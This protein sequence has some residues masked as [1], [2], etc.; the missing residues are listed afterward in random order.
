MKPLLLIFG[1]LMCLQFFAEPAFAFQDSPAGDITEQV[2]GDQVDEAENGEQSEVRELTGLIS[3]GKIVAAI[4]ILIVTW[5]AIYLINNILDNLSE[6]ATRYRL[7]IKR[8]T[9][10]VRVFIWTMAIYVIIVG[11]I[12]PPFEALVTIAASLGIAVGFASQDVLKNIFGG[13]LI[14]FD[15]PFQVGDKIRVGSDYG[16][17]L[18]IGLRST[19]IV[20]P[21][22]SVV[23]LPNGE[24]M[25]KAVSNTNTG[26]L[27]CQV[28]SEIFMPA[29]TDSDLLKSIAYRSVYSS[30]YVYLNK[31]VEV[32]VINEIY[33]QNFVIKLR[34]KAYVLD[35]RYEF[36]FL[37]DVTEQIL[38]ETSAQGLIPVSG[39][40]SKIYD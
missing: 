4:I 36:L 27:Y 6:K 10:I 7:F 24:V 39:G 34:V 3:L 16:E 18:S 12:D 29:H 38:S 33:N 8:L 2:S 26:A 31:P 23:S 9:P 15:R 14:I 22:D 25:N 17:V 5:L 13:I 19:R 20:T 11:V 21:D 28:V 1:I 40:V 35:I 37:S 32:I 30:P